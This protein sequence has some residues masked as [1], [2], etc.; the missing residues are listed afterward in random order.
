M[1]N[2]DYP[3][4]GVEKVN[5]LKELVNVAAGK[6]CDKP[7]ITFER[8]MEI[9][10]VSYRKFKS[11]VDALGTYFYDRFARDAKIALIGEN[12]YEWILTYFA[13]VNGGK[14]IVP[15][16]RE[17]PKED[18]K[19]L[20]L[21]SGAEVFVFSDAF[22]Y[23]ADY[24]KA[25]G[26][27]V[28]HYIN[29]T[30]LPKFLECGRSLLANN[31]TGFLNYEIDERATTA[32]VYT[33]GT[34]GIAK[35]AMLSHRGFA[36]DTVASCQHV[37]AIGSNMLVLP[38]HH[39]LGFTAGVS[40]MLLQGSEIYINSCLKNVLSD[41]EKFKPGT[42]FLVPLFVEIFYKKI[43]ESAKKQGKDKLLKK[44]I[45]LSNGLLKI[46]IDVRR[47][48]FKSVLQAFGGNLALLVSGGAPID[49]KYI[50]GLHYFGMNVL[51]GYGITECSP[52]VAVNRNSYHHD[53][54]VGQVLPC[55][56]C[57]VKIS[58]PDENGHG[59]IYVKGD[60]V[61]NGYYENEQA[62]KEAFDGEWFKTGDI[63]YFDKEGFLYIAGRKKNLIILKNGKNVYP[64]D[65]E[66]SILNY[67][68]YIKEAV[69]YSEDNIIVA[70]VFLD[71]ENN[72]DCVSRLDGDILE[73]NKTLPLYKNIGKTVI[74]DIEFQ[75]TTTKKIK[76]HCGD[77]G[78]SVIN[79]VLGTESFTD[80]QKKIWDIWASAL[81]R[82]DFGI[83]QSFFILDGDSL[84]AVT[85]ICE[86]EAAF[87]KALDVRL[88]YEYNTVE[89]LAGYID[90]KDG[91]RETTVYGYTPLLEREITVAGPKNLPEGGKHVTLLTGCTGYFGAHVLKKLLDGTQDDIYCIIR[92]KKKHEEVMDYYFGGLSKMECARVH[93]LQGDVSE[94]NL[95]LSDRVYSDL[96]AK[97]TRVF[98]SAADVRHFGIWKDSEKANIYGTYYI[99]ELCAACGAQ[100]NHMSSIW[101]SGKNICSQSQAV[102]F[103][104]NTLDIGQGYTENIYVHSK[105][106][107]EVLL[108]KYKDKGLHINTYRLGNLTPRASD[109][110]FQINPTDNGYYMRG[111][112]TGKLGCIPL[113]LKDCMFDITPVDKAAEAVVL[114]A[115]G[116]GNGVWHIYDHNERSFHDYCSELYGELDIVDIPTF[117][118]KLDVLAKDDKSAN[119]FKFYLHEMLKEDAVKYEICF[120]SVK[121]QA[122]LK[123]LNFE[124]Q[125][126]KTAEEQPVSL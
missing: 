11:D 88:I 120:S 7:A 17:L 94:P 63:G 98:H 67:I 40:S 16:D 26:A 22:S 113:E 81:G 41:L 50:T 111:A 86:L 104:E 110:K 13:V 108:N 54:S 51:N 44:L 125:L 114:L 57:E 56:C 74:R 32:I 97:A 90:S 73:L 39:T 70:E 126:E 62:T 118:S 79:E 18:I 46:G 21:D 49:I 28:K 99:A 115:S 91:A 112:I 29:K 121:T 65:V 106:I 58:E 37:K 77:V 100:L 15:L 52:V 1:K 9:I 33:S 6:Y 105:Y 5:T 55:H 116:S 61:M 64:E 66:F 8:N 69:V 119:V 20:V 71:V 10:S 103:E 43:W 93:L 80:T 85:V 68:P 34:T 107:S 12:S 2:R 35:G 24:L 14:I 92:N 123:E 60:S 89:K 3:L 82:R 59:E 19:N 78:K 25:N 38:L 109:G 102:V 117:F 31:E 42:I 27:P 72:P 122:A 4:Y 101:V 96:L 76:R 53:Q 83:D 124:W 95:G 30:T 48:L 36:H 84:T 87:G 45:S 47:T 23:F 75:K